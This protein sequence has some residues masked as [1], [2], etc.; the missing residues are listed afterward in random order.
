M[1]PELLKTF[2]AVCEHMNFTR[3]AQDRLLTQPAVSRQVKQLEQLLGVPLFERLGKSIQ[4][5]DAGRALVPQAAELLGQMERI[6]ESIG[7]YREAERGRL[8]I[9]A[10]TTPGYYLLPPILGEF[11]RDYPAV[12]LQFVVDNSLSIE[13]RV[14]RNELDIALVGAHLGN[15]AIRIERLI[16]D[17]IVCFCGASH[18]LSGRRRVAPETLHEELWVIREKGSATRQLF[19]HRWTAAGGKIARSIELASPEGIKALVGAGLGVSF[20]SIHGLRREFADG[21]LGPV[22]IKGLRLE[23]PIYLIRHAQ[24]HESPA[25]K[26]F[27][28]ILRRQAERS[29]W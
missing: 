25:A 24:K 27:C 6:A 4:L 20:M 26:A 11:H 10:S 13:Q 28:A 9:G 16:Q 8:R 2:L 14:V 17:E 18:R 15:A 5:S 3:G 22:A 19:E 23:R 7:S 12:E 29:A 21:R 1:N